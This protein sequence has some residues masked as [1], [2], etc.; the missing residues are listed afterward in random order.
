MLLAACGALLCLLAC[1]DPNS[2][3][4]TNPTK[5]DPPPPPVLS[6]PVNGW[7]S[8]DTCYP[9]AVG[10]GWQAVHGAQFYEIQVS[11][12]DSL[13]TLHHIVYSNPRIYETGVTASDSTY[14]GYYW[15]VRAASS[16]WNNY[17]NWSDP[18]HFSLPNP[19]P[20][21]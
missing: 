6:D 12:W 2:Y 14:G 17:T 1:R 21:K 3:Q 20:P 18:F 19:R 9:Q 13:F 11:I 15:R 4:P 8:N 7:V 16:N 10:F 5:S